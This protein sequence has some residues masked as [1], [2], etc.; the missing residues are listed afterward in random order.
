MNFNFENIV[1][2]KGRLI[3]SPNLFKDI[4]AIK[5]RS[6]INL[7][8]D[9]LKFV[10]SVSKLNKYVFYN[11]FPKGVEQLAMR[12]PMNVVG[13]ER[14]LRWIVSYTKIYYQQINEFVVLAD[15][16]NQNLLMGNLNVCEQSLDTIEEKFGISV[17]LIKNK[18][19]FL[20]IAKGLEAQKLY[21]A[22]IRH[23]VHPN[24]VAYLL[25]HYI[26]YRNEPTISYFHHINQV[27]DIF[28]NQVEDKILIPFLKF[29]FAA[30]DIL[31]SNELCEVLTVSNTISAIDGFDALQY[32]LKTLISLEISKLKTSSS[33]G[34][35]PVFNELLASLKECIISP[36][37]DALQNEVVN[38][39]VSS[40]LSGKPVLASQIALLY[41][42]DDLAFEFA[43]NEYAENV[44]NFNSVITFSRIFCKNQSLSEIIPDEISLNKFSSKSL[45]LDI[46][47][48][49]ISV[50][51]V[52]DNCEN[53][54]IYLLNLTSN[55]HAYT[56]ADALFGFIVNVVT[57]E[58]TAEDIYYFHYGCVSLPSKELYRTWF[59]VKAKDKYTYLSDEVLKQKDISQATDALF[60]GKGSCLLS[61]ILSQDENT[62]SVV[63]RSNIS[64]QD[65]QGVSSSYS[66]LNSDDKMIRNVALRFYCHFM[67]NSGQTDKCLDFVVTKF[68]SNNGYFAYLP[69]LRLVNHMTQNK[70]I[71]SDPLSLTILLDFNNRLF[72]SQLERRK[73]Y[74]YEDF[75]KA[76]GVDKPSQLNDKLK[77]FNKIKIIYFLKEICVEN[78]FSKSVVFRSSQEVVRERLLVCKLLIEVDP[79]NTELYQNEIK[80]IQ[81]KIMI[82]R[83]VKEIEKSKIYV[84]S[85]QLK[86]VVNKQIKD[87]F[88]RYISLIK[89]GIDSEYFV[90]IEAQMRDTYSKMRKDLDGA[91]Y[92]ETLLSLDLPEN[93]TYALFESMIFDLLDLFVSNTEYGLDGYLSTR[94]RHGTLSTQLR[95]NL[96]LA[97]LIT[98][99]IKTAGGYE[100][101]PDTYW[102][103]EL[104]IDGQDLALDLRAALSEFS[105]SFDLLI[106][107]I[108][109]D[110]VQIKKASDDKGLF[111]FTLNKQGII[112]LSSEVIATTTFDEFL[113]EVF[114]Q[115]YLSLEIILEKFREKV[116]LEVKPE[117]NVMFDTL[118]RKV[119]SLNQ[120]DDFGVLN[121]AI[122]RARY[123]VQA[124]VD[125]VTE[126]FRLSREFANEPFTVDDSI[127]ISIDSIATLYP[128]FD[129]TLSISEDVAS[130]YVNGQYLAN[131][132]DIFFI[133]FENMVKHSGFFGYTKASV[134]A[135]LKNDKIV[136]YI[137]NDIANKELAQVS[138]YKIN[139]IKE[140]ISKNKSQEFVNLEG[141]SGFFKIEKILQYDISHEFEDNAP[142]LAFDV[143]DEKF[144]V[145]ISFPFTPSKT[146]DL[147]NSNRG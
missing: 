24:S 112:I 128:D 32:V 21:S 46:I 66:L 140:Y 16:F 5:K 80:D 6:P 3:N 110:W 74:A 44:N 143:A 98:Q 139:R 102:T 83:R 111:D 19:A 84:N 144:F 145:E 76:N 103:N 134:L 2:V 113:E 116:I 50:F 25:S 39:E 60:K 122:N 47:K 96:E 85:D 146:I 115:F 125:R 28:E 54:L 18:I 43:K 109:G 117:V 131:Y 15:R 73:K 106:E 10:T 72:G 1:S 69:I 33:S 77:S 22:S 55:F 34:I 42:Q 107:K 133:V 126:W 13:I 64:D 7:Y 136:V 93:E 49:L 123:D 30:H 63:L 11:A 108:L 147:E 62:L 142:T 114:K 121:A 8:G 97:H 79:N 67:I 35:I 91:A 120:I 36:V 99:R 68:I 81:R 75:L 118:L 101:L 95:S 31:E 61:D 29:H 57:N 71:T 141:G 87:K 105:Q 27:K 129:A 14:E 137:E 104:N 58:T 51:Q 86:L 88:A 53:S 78:I 132:I 37:L 135:Y 41:G 90:N 45:G 138:R 59:Y 119:N 40:N 23:K 20:Q 48:K 94:I 82:R 89:E 124:S 9:I 26:S 92:S 12:R 56:W 127:N 70:F 38:I 4:N 130:I 17:W 65:L 100:Y 52:D